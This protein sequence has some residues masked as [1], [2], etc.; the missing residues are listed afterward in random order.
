MA[1]KNYTGCH[2]VLVG[3]DDDCLIDEVLLGFGLGFCRSHA[4]PTG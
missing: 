4:R 2:G 1:K 3:D